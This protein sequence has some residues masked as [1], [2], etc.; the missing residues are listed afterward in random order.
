MDVPHIS[1][2]RVSVIQIYKQVA[3]GPWTTRQL[4]N[5]LD[6]EPADIRAALNY[7]REHVDEMEEWRELMEEEKETLREQIALARPEGVLPP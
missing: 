1:G 5:E 3:E 6:L 4:A 7:Y 2:R